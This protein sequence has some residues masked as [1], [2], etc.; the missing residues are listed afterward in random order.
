VAFAVLV[1][2]GQY[3]GRAAAPLAVKVVAAAR[4]LGV[5][6]EEQRH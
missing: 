1:E 2:N 3:G 4:E 6:S 5:L